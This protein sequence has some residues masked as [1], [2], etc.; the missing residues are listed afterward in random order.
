MGH[1][2]RLQDLWFNWRAEELKDFR[3]IDPRTKAF[4]TEMLK[5]PGEVNSAHVNCLA[6]PEKTACHTPLHVLM[7]TRRLNSHITMR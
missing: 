6:V 3:G 5:D 1:Y 2:L 4:N 7:H